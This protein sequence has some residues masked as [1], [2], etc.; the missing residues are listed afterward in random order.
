[1]DLNIDNL[2]F[3]ADKSWMLL[4]RTI[5]GKT[6][7]YPTVAPC[8]DFGGLIALMEYV[9][10]SHLDP[11]A[12]K[13][14]DLGS[15]DG[16]VVFLARLFG[17]EAYGIELQAGLFNTAKNYQSI[18]DLIEGVTFFH[19]NWKRYSAFRDIGVDFKDID[20]FYLYPSA[21]CLQRAYDMISRT[22]KEGTV[23][24]VKKSGE[25]SRARLPTNLALVHEIESMSGPVRVYIR[26]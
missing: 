8:E 26:R 9:S 14:M 23:L 1:M 16:I 4:R 7:Y 3:L 19:A 12:S 10:Q 20:F 2:S 24:A 21:Y 5:F 25:D 17:F 18:L 11:A 6:C 13:F 22:S 15:G